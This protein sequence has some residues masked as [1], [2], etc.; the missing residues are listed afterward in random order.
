MLFPPSY[1]LFFPK[2]PACAATA[3]LRTPRSTK[4]SRV[5]QGR[6]WRLGGLKVLVRDLPGG[7]TR[8]IIKEQSSGAVRDLMNY[9]VRGVLEADSTELVESC[10]WRPSP[11]RWGEVFIACDRRIHA[12]SRAHARSSLGSEFVHALGARLPQRREA[13]YVKLIPS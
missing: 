11:R 10:P 12:E 5:L 7:R 13:V 6:N 3:K 4:K 8:F 1:K 9:D 2:S